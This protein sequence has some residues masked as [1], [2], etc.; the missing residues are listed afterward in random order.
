M[1]LPT[2][3]IG[4]ERPI[5]VFVIYHLSNLN[6]TMA[7]KMVPR[8]PGSCIIKKTGVWRRET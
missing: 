5:N 6:S 2:F 3:I 8:Q 1:Y 7:Y 4:Y